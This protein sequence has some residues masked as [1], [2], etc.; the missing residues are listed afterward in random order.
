MGSVVKGSVERLG[1]GNF[2][3]DVSK[4]I[5]PAPLSKLRRVNTWRLDGG[6]MMYARPYIAY[7]PLD[8]QMLLPRADDLVSMLGR[9]PRHLKLIPMECEWWPSFACIDVG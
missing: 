6:S 7:S 8:S 5:R 4:M 9:F 1:T 3:V 2:E